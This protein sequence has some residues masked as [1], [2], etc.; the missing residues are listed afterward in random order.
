MIPLSET[1]KRKKEAKVYIDKVIDQMSLAESDLKKAIRHNIGQLIDRCM[2]YSNIGRKFHFNINPDLKQKVNDILDQLQKDLFNIIYLR[3]ENTSNLAQQKEDN[4]QNNKYLIALLTSEIAD[5]TLDMR[6]SQYVA[7][8]RSEVEAFVAAGIARGMSRDQIL[9]D[10]I[11]FL[12]APYA[13]PLIIEAFNQK[14]FVAERIVN[15]GISFGTGKYVSA[16]NNL[17]RLEQDTVFRA[18]N[19]TL[20]SIWLND[21]DIIG[22]YTVR[23]S[24][25]SCHICDDQIGVFHSKSD[26][27]TGYHLRCYC[28]MIPVFLND[29]I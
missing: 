16:Y 2:D 22:W 21:W 18:Y 1:D 11:N 5:K 27:F 25:Y 29:I 17:K 12:K 4:P 26:F 19:Y 3:A 7:M 14:G 15:K 10:Y 23:G 28:I 6:I 20:N 24:T 13:A 9:N 8:M